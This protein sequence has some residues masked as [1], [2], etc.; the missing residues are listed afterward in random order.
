M[1]ADANGGAT[2]GATDPTAMVGG[3]GSNYV[4]THSGGVTLTMPAGEP[5]RYLGFYWTAGSP[6]NV[7][8]FYSGDTEIL[9]L[10]TEDLS[11]N[12]GTMPVD[13]ASYGST[14]T[15]SSTGGTPYV[16]HHYFGNPQGVSGAAS[17][18]VMDASLWWNN[19]TN[20]GPS[21]I[22]SPFV[23]VH[24]FG[25]GGMTFDR[26]VFSGS[27]F[28]IDNIVLSS[29]SSVAPTSDL[30]R[31]GGITGTPPPDFNPPGGGGGPDIDL[32]HYT[33][34]AEMPNTGRRA[35]GLEW[36]AAVF[37]AAGTA[38]IGG[39]RRFRQA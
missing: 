17:P 33:E 39:R 37:V 20:Y 2:A 15:I 19:S 29:L 4:Y 26:V 22:S 35:P 23:Y 14:G 32:D 24:V 11:S 10:D 34:T 18:P 8:T 25:Q 27:Y 7:V 12:L 30:V 38:L 13:Q 9:Q 36:I 16:K 31:L 5:Q 3:S 1:A 28:E 6:G 21:R